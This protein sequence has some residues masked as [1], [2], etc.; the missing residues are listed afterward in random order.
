MPVVVGY[1]PTPEGRA[2][3][4]RAAEEC[5]APEH[6]AGGDQLQPR[7]QGPGRRGDGPVRASSWTRSGPSWDRWGSTH[8][9]RQLVRGME[10][11]EDLIAAS[12][13]RSRRLHRD[14][15]APPDPGRQADPGLERA[16]DPARGA[17]PGA[18]GQ[19]RPDVNCRGAAGRARRP[20]AQR[21]EADAG[22]LAA[23]PFALLTGMLLD[24]QFPMERR[25]P[26]RR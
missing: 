2:A 4:R 26:A 12:P 25:S 3:L 18:R 23:D 14:R 5:R 6:P 15:A 10:P 21:P 19:G 20:D 9:V 16:A 1:M 11:A 8:E 22:L 7:R 24:Q 13:R 17:L